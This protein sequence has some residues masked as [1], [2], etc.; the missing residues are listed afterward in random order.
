MALQY[1]TGKRAS[2]YVRI[3]DPELPNG[4]IELEMR[5]CAHCGFHG[6]YNPGNAKQYLK[7]IGTS[8]FINGVCIPCGGL[9]C[10]K[11]ECNE[12]CEVLEKR[13]EDYESGK[14]LTL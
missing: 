9:T 11:K 10:M 6:L 1:F 7:Y 2:S 5:M 4:Y 8:N 14:R 13:I 3:S 12:K